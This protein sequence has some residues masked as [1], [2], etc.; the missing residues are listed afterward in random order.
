MADGL[1][2]LSSPVED[3]ILVLNILQELNQRFEHVG[4]IIWPYLPFP[5]FLKVLDCLLLEEIHMDST[6]LS[7][8][9]KALY[10]NAA[11]PAARSPSSTSSRPPSG[12]NSGNSSPT[13]GLRR[14]HRQVGLRAQAPC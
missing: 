8:A 6:D 13:S 10:I 4:S 3:W 5:N 12:G 11:P 14:Y 7:A 2:D 1:A 9:P